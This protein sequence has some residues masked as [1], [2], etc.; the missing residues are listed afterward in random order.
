MAAANPSEALEAQLLWP[1]PWAPA[2]QDPNAPGKSL[3]GDNRISCV[4]D[5]RIEKEKQVARG[6]QRTLVADI[7]AQLTGYA[8]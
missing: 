7:S 3:N 4:G 1:C 2:W 5:Q 8:K 6:L